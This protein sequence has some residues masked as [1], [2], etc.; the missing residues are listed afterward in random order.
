MGCVPS[1][2]IIRSARVV[3]E[4]R[5]A[6]RFGVRPSGVEV[7]FPAVMERT[8]RI[9]AG[10]SHHDSAER[11]RALGVDVFL[12]EARFLSPDRVEVGAS[13]L[14]FNKAVIATG[15]RPVAPPIEGLAAVGYLTNETVFS[16]TERPRRLAVIGA[17]PIGCEL[18]QAFALLGSEV[19]LIEK[20]SQLLIREDRDAA[21]MLA[22]ALAR[23]GVQIKLG[24]SVRRV[25]V[26]GDSKVLHLESDTE[27]ESLPVDQILVGVGRAPNI[28]DLN[29]ESAGVAY[30]RTGVVVNDYL[31]TTNSKIYAAGDVCLSHRFTHTA[32]ATA[33]I[34][35]QNSLFLGRKKLSRLTIPWCTYTTPEVAHVGMHEH[36]VSANGIELDTYLIPM[37]RVDRAITDGSDDGFV[38]IHVRKGSDQIL[39]ATIVAEHAGEMIS[40]VTLAMVHG[41]GLGKISSVIHPYPTHAEGIK[42]VADAYNRTRLTPLVKKLTARWLAWT[43]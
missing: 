19:T 33:R 8:R 7:D 15:A 9:R 34:V 38:K 1:K 36:D 21:E 22:S 35:I 18:A 10:I 4:L 23:D 12:G 3:A 13:V 25:V 2:M 16:L 14:R 6:Q 42:K 30:K 20:D 41:V 32:D 24:T 26:A 11:F 29:L 17:G 28:E 31:Q 39:G 37:K 43:R 40:E 5:A 27:T